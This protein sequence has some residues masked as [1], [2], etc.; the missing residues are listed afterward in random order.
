[1]DSTKIKAIIVAVLALFAALY[2]GIAAATAQ[3]ETIIWVVGA[4]S[5]SICLL[6][7][8]RVYL[9]I[10]LLTS[11]ALVLPLP[12]MFSSGFISQAVFLGFATPLF[13]LR[14]LPMR[15]KFTELEFWMLLLFA[16][17]VQVYVRNPVGLDIFGSTTVGAK[18]Y[19]VFALSTI[20]A[21]VLST[22]VINPKDLKIWTYLTMVGSIG[23]FIIGAVGFAIPAIGYYLGATFTAD[24]GGRNNVYS[25]ASRIAFVRSLSQHLAI[26]VSSRKSPLTACFSPKWLPLVLFSIALAAFSG[27][28][29]QLLLIGMTFF[30]GVCYRGGIKSVIASS[31]L[32][33]LILFMLIIVNMVAPLP[34]NIQRTL[35]VLPGT[36]DRSVVDESQQS[37]DWRV[38]MWIAALTTDKWIHNKILG[39]GLG[40][41][42]EEYDRML[43]Y[44]NTAKANSASRIGLTQQQETFLIN[45]SYHSG[46]VQTIRTSGYVGL[47]IMLMAMIR[48]AVHAHRQIQRCRGTEWYPTALFLGIPLIVTPIHWSLLIGTFDEAAVGVMMGIAVIRLMEENLPLPAYAIRRSVLVGL[49]SRAPVRA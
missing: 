44:D 14:R 4:V 35:T 20:C 13:L 30:V 39:D 31:I 16:S 29:A 37:S 46:P 41:T 38:E 18:P 40:F 48:L 34:L 10:P 5:V 12:G 8:T 36:W 17:V 15:F 33:V 45:G 49:P 27:Y 21:A 7:G 43:V 11:L 24:I 26:W 25:G 9:L 6:L 22:L 23:N 3:F 47:A 1:M 28:R 2:L 32:G 19:A 42:K